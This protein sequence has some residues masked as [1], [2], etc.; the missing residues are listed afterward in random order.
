MREL[1]NTARIRRKTIASSYR[2]HSR[3]LNFGIHPAR[4][5][6][7]NRLGELRLFLHAFDPHHIRC[8]SIGFGHKSGTVELNCPA[9]FSF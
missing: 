7:A 1:I 8:L 4:S 9:A 3:L 2:W 6:V 5:A